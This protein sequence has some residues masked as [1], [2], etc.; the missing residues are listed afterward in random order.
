MWFDPG[1]W[2]D[3]LVEY[4]GV[5]RKSRIVAHLESALWHSSMSG[6][7]ITLV[8]A[9]TTQSAGS[10]ERASKSFNSTKQL[11]LNRIDWPDARVNVRIARIESLSATCPLH[12]SV[13]AEWSLRS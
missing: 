3:V 12:G 4:E 6:K 13:D 1:Q 2:P 10:I 5:G 8:I 11:V 9:T 7:L